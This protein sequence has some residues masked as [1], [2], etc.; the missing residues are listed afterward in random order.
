MRGPRHRRVVTGFA[1]LALA[2]LLGC[3]GET[4]P[5]GWGSGL[6]KDQ[7]DS[8]LAVASP[9]AA[10]EL[11]PLSE[12]FYGRITSRRFNSRATFEDPSVRQFFPTVA[13]YSDYYAAL[14]DALDRA[15]I[16]YNR[17]TRVEL[18]GI[19]VAA[20]GN[21]FLELRFVGRN[22]LPLRWW[23]ASLVRKDEW[24]WQDERWYVVPG[25]V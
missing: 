3:A 17:P 23:S 25:K 21:L 9:R 10:R 12:V 20:S 24:T 11:V 6:T 7:R 14:V 2:W 16:R 8:I 19:E 18:L 15:Y 4:G 5:Q 22:D 13:A 1:M